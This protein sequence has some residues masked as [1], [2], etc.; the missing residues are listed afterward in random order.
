M[1]FGLGAGRESFRFSN[2]PGGYSNEITKPSF[3]LA[4][5]GTVNVALSVA[6]LL[7]LAIMVI[8]PGVFTGHDPSEIDIAAR[9]SG[10]TLQLL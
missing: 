3:W 7:L 6:Y 5:G 9:L 1:T 10:L 8:A 4:A 2:V